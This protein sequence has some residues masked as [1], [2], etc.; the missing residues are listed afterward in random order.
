MR[1]WVCVCV[2]FFIQAH[3]ACK[4]N[5]RARKT[6][7][8]KS[9][10]SPSKSL[11][12]VSGVDKSIRLFSSRRAGKLR[13][14]LGFL[15]RELLTFICRVHRCKGGKREI[16]HSSKSDDINTGAQETTKKGRDTRPLQCPAGTTE[17]RHDKQMGY[18]W[19]SVSRA[20]RYWRGSYREVNLTGLEGAPT[21][22]K[23]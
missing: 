10:D 11:E 18:S 21:P 5:S 22:H 6:H 19:T 12:G 23:C 7:H 8:R 3:S 17:K 1:A 14:L 13:I 4:N 9:A 16:R 2:G 15:N 20:P